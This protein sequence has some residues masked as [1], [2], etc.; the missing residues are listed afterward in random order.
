VGDG[1]AVDG[2]EKESRQIPPT[3][4]EFDDEDPSEMVWKGELRWVPGVIG[5]KLVLLGLC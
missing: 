5:D 4:G 3:S 2:T 1:D